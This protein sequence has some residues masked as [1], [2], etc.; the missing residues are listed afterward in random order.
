MPEIEIV[1]VESIDRSGATGCPGRLSAL[2]QFAQNRA[3]S[4]FSWPHCVQN[5][6]GIGFVVLPVDV[7]AVG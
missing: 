2:P 4:G 6:V 1:D 7:A 3:S 5:T